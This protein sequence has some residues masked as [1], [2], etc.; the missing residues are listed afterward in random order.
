M[1]CRKRLISFNASTAPAFTQHPNREIVNID[2]FTVQFYISMMDVGTDLFGDE[3]GFDVLQSRIDELLEEC[4]RLREEN[5]MLR[6]QQAVLMEDRAQL[7]DRN[8]SARN[9]VEAIVSR[10]KDLEAEV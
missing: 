10:L 5:R 3:V 9:K 6:T 4:Q 7:V 2:P 8:E 1:P